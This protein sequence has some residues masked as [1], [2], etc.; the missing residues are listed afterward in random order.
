LTLKKV[1]FGNT[2]FEVSPLVY[3]TLPLGPL[4]AD[5]S[6][7]RGGELIRFAMERGVTLIDT[8]HLYGTFDH[9]REGL[10]GCT[11]RR[12]WRG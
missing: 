1:A 6:P 9:V 12:P 2:G 5:V 11:W 3:G 8:A 7:E 10:R 4:Q